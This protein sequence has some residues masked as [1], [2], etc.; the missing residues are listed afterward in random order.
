VNRV[1]GDK[2]G[3]LVV[4][5]IGIGE[6]LRASLAA[7]DPSV[8]DE[9]TIPLETAIARL[10][11]KHEVVASMLH[12]LDFS[13]WR[14][15]APQARYELV[16]GAVDRV[17]ADEEDTKRF[18]AEQNLFARWYKLVRPHEP[19]I[20]MGDDA[21][22]FAAVAGAARKLSASG[23][24]ADPAAEQAVKQ[25]LSEGL[26]AGEVVDVFAL[27]GDDRPE[28][29]VLSD[30]FLDSLTARTENPHLGI[31]ALRRLLE[32]EVRTQAR[33]NQMRAKLFSERIGELLARYNLRQ[34]STAEIIREL[35]ELAKRMRAARRRNE[36][37]GLSREELAFYDALAGGAEPDTI[38]VDP[39][40]AEIARE[41]VKGIR[42]DLTVDWTSRASAEAAIR[43]KIKRLLRRH[44]FTA[45]S[46][47]GLGGGV[48]GSMSTDEVVSL[49][50][51]QARA[52][53]AA[54]PEV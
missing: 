22:F 1:F 40:I 29:S 46:G 9:V 13:G 49:I 53:Y 15:L 26:A 35:V 31:A 37:L 27:M 32:S 50:L 6:D 33:Q 45:A 2:P 7:Y 24:T 30:E 48:G 44:K 23:G 8:A 38:E 5:Y 41:L 20:A 14:E 21:E 18:L 4:D 11:E 10:R 43:V 17:L 42:A 52:L 28:L 3:G 54:W 39:R 16:I 36:E 47:S 12:G 51:N 34:L 19:A 25:F